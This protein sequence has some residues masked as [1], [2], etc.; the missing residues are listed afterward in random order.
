MNH[1]KSEDGFSVIEVLVAFALLSL[2]LTTLYR[3]MSTSFAGL[4]L[5]RSR[6][7][8]V[9]HGL[10]ELDMARHYPQAASDRSGRYPNGMMWRVWSDTLPLAISDALNPS[11]P[12][13]VFFEAT[14][15]SGQP[16]IQL[17]TV[18]LQ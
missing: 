12:R 16:L 5:A 11:R 4:A 2:T 18:T 15:A 1:S 17:R 14:S 3:V 10:S 6:D 9:V 7:A 8:I 13:W